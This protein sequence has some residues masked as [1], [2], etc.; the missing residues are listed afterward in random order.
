MARTKKAFHGD[1]KKHKIRLAKTN[2]I[3]AR[4]FNEKKLYS[5]QGNALFVIF[6]FN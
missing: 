4:G 2:T 5:T 1:S 3:M 6:E